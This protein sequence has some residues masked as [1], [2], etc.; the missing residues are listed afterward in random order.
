MFFTESD[1]TVE[2]SILDRLQSIDDTSDSFFRWKEL[3]VF[4]TLVAPNQCDGTVFEV[5]RTD[6]DANG[7][8]FLDPLPC[9]DATTEVALVDLD[10]DL[11]AVERL[12]TDFV[13]QFLASCERLA[14]WSASCRSTL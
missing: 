1:S 2:E 9:F 10:V 12:S 3:F 8:A 6:F 7:N 11:F 13:G 5:A 4:W 14:Q